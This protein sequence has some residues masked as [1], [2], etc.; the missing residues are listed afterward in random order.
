MGACCEFLGFVCF[1]RVRIK[2]LSLCAILLLESKLNSKSSIA[3]NDSFTFRTRSKK[4]SPPTQQEPPMT[5]Y[6]TGLMPAEHTVVLQNVSWE[7]YEHLL[8]DHVDASTPRF[9]FDRGVLEVMSPS[10]EHERYKQ[11]LSLLVEML[12]DGLGIDIENL[13]STTLDRKSVV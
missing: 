2:K 6:D 11:A 5:T 7:T 1:R 13:G 9:T 10:A 3:H 12:A 4:M 8:A